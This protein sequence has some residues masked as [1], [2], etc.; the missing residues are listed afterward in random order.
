[1]SPDAQRH[2]VRVAIVEQ[3]QAASRAR[4]REVGAFVVV[5]DVHRRRRNGASKLYVFSA[6]VIEDRAAGSIRPKTS[7]DESHGCPHVWRHALT[8]SLPST[9]L[10]IFSPTDKR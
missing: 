6:A 10:R 1:M 5:I 8:P 4:P 7:S 9:P 2:V 3:R